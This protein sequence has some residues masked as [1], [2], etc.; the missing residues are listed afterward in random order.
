MR[1]VINAPP[2]LNDAPIALP[3]LR[4]PRRRVKKKETPRKKD[5][6]RPEF[7]GLVRPVQ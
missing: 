3:T 6:V 5:I 4:A 7:R 2:A 1:A